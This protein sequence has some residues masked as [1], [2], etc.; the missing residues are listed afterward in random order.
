MLV[1]AKQIVGSTTN[2]ERPC[3]G[4][5]DWRHVTAQIKEV[6]KV[7]IYTQQWTGARP[8]EPEGFILM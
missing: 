7:Y 4:V 5:E 6:K 2:I 8:T 3:P 1:Y